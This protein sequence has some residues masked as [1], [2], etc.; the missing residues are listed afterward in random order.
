MNRAKCQPIAS[1]PLRKALLPPPRQPQYSAY[2]EPAH[3]TAR[4]SAHWIAM[5]I[6]S[7]LQA[8]QR[9]TQN[10]RTSQVHLDAQCI[11]TTSG[12]AK[13]CIS[14]TSGRNAAI[15]RTVTHNGFA[16]MHTSFAD[17]RVKHENIASKSLHEARLAELA[18]RKSLYIG[19]RWAGWHNIAHGSSQWVH[20]NAD[21]LRNESLE[22]RAY[23]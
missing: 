16:I 11:L 10:P 22:A 2:Q 18:G 19:N 9:V 14:R 8:A 17:S 15:S 6:R 21:K 5:G 1:I 4:Y 20:G 12:T 7:R 3:G 13:C 23:C